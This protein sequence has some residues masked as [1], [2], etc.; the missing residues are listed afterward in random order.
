MIATLL[1]AAALAAK[2]VEISHDD[3]APTPVW[4]LPGVRSV[5]LDPYKGRG[6]EM[7]P[8][9]NT[10]PEGIRG[11]G[12]IVYDDVCDN[13]YVM[14]RFDLHLGGK[15]PFEYMFFRREDVSTEPPKSN[16]WQYRPVVG[17]L[18]VAGFDGRPVEAIPLDDPLWTAHRMLTRG[19]KL[20]VLDADRLIV[21]DGNGHELAIE[22]F[23]VG[24][25]DPYRFV[26][27]AQDR[28]LYAR[29]ATGKLDHEK[30]APLATVPAAA[31]LLAKPSSGRPVVVNLKPEW[32]GTDR[33]FSPAWLDPT[34]QI[35]DH[36]C[37]EKERRDL[38]E[39]CG[40]YWLDYSAFGAWW[41]TKEVL[42]VAL[43]DGVIDR[44][45]GE[46]P[47]LRIVVKQPWTNNIRVSP[48][49]DGVDPGAGAVSSPP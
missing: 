40:R 8:S 37:D 20:D 47:V 19:E 7:K 2:P 21:R 46:I 41:P 4:T 5:E 26:S 30:A 45:D 28:A 27:D 44:G 13:S 16:E 36:T 10:A 29:F 31:A 49:W 22:P 12:H 38:G 24:P 9:D 15:S 18:Y 25:E 32:L 23:G 17:T 11:L 1:I 35:L 43:T 33:R 6:C 34:G 39:P 3:K 42:T 48:G 14:V